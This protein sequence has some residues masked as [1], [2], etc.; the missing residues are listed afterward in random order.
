MKRR[1]FLAR[2]GAALIASAMAKLGVA[3]P[4]RERIRLRPGRRP[5]PM[6][7]LQGSVDGRTW[8]VLSSKPAPLDVSG[9]GSALVNASWTDFGRVPR[10][11]RYMRFALH[12]PAESRPLALIPIADPPAAGTRVATMGAALRLRPQ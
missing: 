10:Q 12:L 3:L 4:I 9:N 2:A 8:E 1:L 5:V 11:F 6:L 7:E